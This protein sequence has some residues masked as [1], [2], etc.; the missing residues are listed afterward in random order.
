M[1]V[2]GSVAVLAL[3]GATKSAH[4]IKKSPIKPLQYH[5]NEDAP[6]D[7]T[8]VLWKVTPTLPP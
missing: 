6:E 8:T 3:L 2:Q 4:V 7:D 5:W 1:K